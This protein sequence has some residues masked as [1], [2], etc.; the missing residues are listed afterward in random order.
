LSFDD[1]EPRT[2]TGIVYDVIAG[3]VAD[4]AG[5]SPWST[6]ACAANDVP[7]PP[8]TLSDVPQPGQATY[9]LVRAQG[10]RGRGS[11]GTGTGHP[12][13][14]EGWNAHSACN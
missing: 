4:L 8:A 14:S 2:G 10:S 6:T 7:S 12:D 3:N 9:Y 5:G 1:Q 11:Y 13:P